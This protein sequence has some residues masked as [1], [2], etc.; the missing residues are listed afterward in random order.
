[1]EDDRSGL[2]NSD[3]LNETLQQLKTLKSEESV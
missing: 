3:L 2:E 1:M